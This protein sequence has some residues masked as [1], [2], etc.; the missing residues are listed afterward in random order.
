MAS[1]NL[2]ATRLDDETLL[3]VVTTG[4]CSRLTPAQKVAYY[5][6]RCEVAGLDE[7]TAPFQFIPA[8][9][10]LILYATKAA[11]EQLVLKHRLKVEVLSQETDKDIRVVTVR[12]TAPDGRQTDDIGCVTVGKAI[13]DAL[14]NALMKA[15]TKAKR[16]AV[17]SICGLGMLDETEIETIP[18]A[19]PP[20]PAEFQVREPVRETRQLQETSVPNTGDRGRAVAPPDPPVSDTSGVVGIWKSPLLREI[21]AEFKDPEPMAAELDAVDEKARK[22]RIGDRVLEMTGGDVAEAKR[23]LMFYT[24]QQQN[25]TFA[26]GFNSLKSPLATGERLI[27]LDHRVRE[28]WTRWKKEHAK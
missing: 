20:I 8:G 6:N 2:P 21:E 11:S 15:V 1:D 27:A 22:Q 12:V 28:E 26:L 17:L 23:L 7:R 14:C 18:G 16:R 19:G 3:L 13:G 10:K 5:R 25:G 4:D 24:T 9:G